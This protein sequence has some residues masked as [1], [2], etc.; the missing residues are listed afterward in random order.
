MKKKIL[1]LFLLLGVVFSAFACGG[2]ETNN[3]VSSESQSTSENSTSVYEPIDYVSQLKLNMNSETLKQE[4]TVKF[5]IDGDTTHFHVPTSINK[6]GVLKARYLAVNTPESTGTIEEWGKKASNFTKSAL[7]NAQSII[8]E[9]N[10]TKWEVDSTGDRYLVWVWYK[11]QGATEYRNLNLELLQ[12]GLALAS[13]SSESRYGEYCTKA[14]YQANLLDLHVYSDEKD[15]DYW[16]GE[17]VELDLREL[18]LNFNKYKDKD[19]AFE[20]VISYYYNKGIYVEKFDDETQRY[21]GIYVYYGHN[22]SSFGEAMLKVGTKVRIVGNAQNFNGSYQI[23]NLTYDPFDTTNPNNVQILDD[24]KYETANTVTTA[25]EFLGNTTIQYEDKATGDI[26]TKTGKYGSFAIDTSI[27]MENLYVRKVSTT[28]S[29]NSEGAMTLYCDVDGKEISV[30]T[31]VL[32]DENGD[33]ITKDTFVGKT[34]TVKGVVDYYSDRDIYQI[35][36]FHMDNV[37]FVS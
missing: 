12:N 29:G 6:D 26:V 22:F 14:V 25:A 15:P 37:T 24:K 9:T 28:Q 16:Y 35:Q 4:V 11:P 10:G 30:R 23:S 21:Y 8:V 27:C 36:I 19:V 1:S 17:A 3:S 20:G 33:I 5:F 2:G 18:R 31:L 13:N 32:T 7:S 34:I